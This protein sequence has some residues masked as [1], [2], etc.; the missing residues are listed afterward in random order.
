MGGVG[1]VAVLPLLRT[2]GKGTTCQAVCHHQS[3]AAI[4]G[5]DVSSL[6]NVA[7]TLLQLEVMPGSLLPQDEQ[8]PSE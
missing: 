3:P 4:S 6:L 7:A 2:K 1:I 5:S 8:G